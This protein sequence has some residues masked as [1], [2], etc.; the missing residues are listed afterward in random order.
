MSIESEALGLLEG[1]FQLQDKD[2]EDS[3]DELVQTFA[4]ESNIEQAMIE[5][6]AYCKANNLTADDLLE[7]NRISDTNFEQYYQQ[8][9]PVKAKLLKIIVQAG[10]EIN[11]KILEKGLHPIVKVRV[12][13]LEHNEKLP[14]YAHEL[15]DSGLDVFLTDDIIIPPQGT[16]KART[17]IKVVIPVGYELQVRP[18]SGMSL[19][20]NNVY[21]FIAN[22]PGTIDA[23]FREEIEIILKNLSDKPVGFS[24]GIKIAQLVLCPVIKLQWE[25]IENVNDFPTERTGGFGST[26]EK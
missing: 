9:S 19:N 23:N 13:K 18:K 6:I 8:L 1:I 11:K 14:A 22:S 15:G 21:L 5:K 20:P 17:G 24:K 7:E 25:E 3:F 12:Q 4:S 16:M 10:V 2:I 26:G